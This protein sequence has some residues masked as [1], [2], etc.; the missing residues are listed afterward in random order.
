M[1][2]QGTK[3]LAHWAV[4]RIIDTKGGL[5]DTPKTL[6]WWLVEPLRW[7]LVSSLPCKIESGEFSRHLTADFF[8]SFG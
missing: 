7:P 4:L 8:N 2:A 3:N 1:K 5:V 6:S